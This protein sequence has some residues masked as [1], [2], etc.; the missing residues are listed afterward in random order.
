MK[1]DAEMHNADDMKKKEAVEAKNIAEQTI[2][3]AEKALKDA[4]DKVPADLRKS[5]ED[6]IADVK[7]TK[8]GAD[9]SKAKSATEALGS[10]MP[11]I[12]EILAKAQAEAS[13]TETKPED[14]K[15]GDG[16]VRDAEFK[17]GEKK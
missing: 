4:G 14:K 16:P 2:Y 6:K 8:E 1:K 5:I 13:K 17:E 10:E 15:A 11:K 3:T 9:A 12:G 7:T